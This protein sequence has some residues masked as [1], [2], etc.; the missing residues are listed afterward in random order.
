MIPSPITKVEQLDN[1]MAMINS[2]DALRRLRGYQSMMQP[3][4]IQR[5][6]GGVAD[7]MPEEEAAVM[8]EA[9]QGAQEGMQ[10]AEQVPP[11]MREEYA[12]DIAELQEAAKGLAAMGRMG[13]TEL[14]HMSADELQGL[15][16]LGELTYN[17]VTGLPEAFKLGRVF[18]SIT[19]APRAI[20]KGV[21]NVVRSK[22]FKTLAPI[23]LGIAAPYALGAGG[24]GLFSTTSALGF[25]AATALGTGLGSLLAG[26]KP[27]DALKSA[28]ISGV[29]AG[30][31]KGIGNKMAGKPF[32]GGAQTPPPT[33]ELG[34]YSGD[35]GRASYQPASS[36]PTGTPAGQI[37]PNL[38]SYGDVAKGISGPGISGA[39]P[40]DIAS[41]AYP[42]GVPSSAPAGSVNYANLS[43]ADKAS[44]LQQAISAQP[45]VSPIVQK[46][47]QP[48]AKSDKMVYNSIN[49][50]FYKDSTKIQYL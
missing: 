2:P 13:D 29:T 48:M 47:V 17:P 10:L 24:L 12:G 4:I 6:M 37:N 11:E 26:Q 25:G 36:V 45:K 44:Q 43:Q 39:S 35:F 22:A 32:M 42:G 27:S 9:Q 5:E 31:T 19:R 15:M 40:S 21:K 16:S 14:V 3:P 38:S 1:Q 23:V 18:K 30:V 7:V 50:N 33:G 34:T 8:Q 20:A 49:N 28:L 41:M 46:P